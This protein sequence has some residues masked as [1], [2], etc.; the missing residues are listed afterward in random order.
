MLALVGSTYAQETTAPNDDEIFHLSPFSVNESAN[1][2]RYQAVEASSGSRIRMNLMD[3]TQSIS[4]LTNEFLR[5]IDTTQLLDA[6][7]Y[8]A[9]IGVSNS[10]NIMDIM[11]IRGFQDYGRSTV[12]GLTQAIYINQDPIIIERMEVVKGPNAIIAPQGLP[13]GVINNVTKKPLF[14]N[15]GSASYQVGRYDS[16][17]AEVDA[18]Y[19]VKD[20]KLA[21]R[22][23]GAVTDADRYLNDT[24]YQNITVMPMLTY[25]FS[26][27]AE[28]TAQVIA[29]N[30]NASDGQS[31]MSPY[32]AGRSNIRILDG[33]PRDFG[34]LGR[35]L[36]RH[37]S[38]QRVQLFFTGQITD[39]LST[40]VAA[41]WAERSARVSAMDLGKLY[42]ASGNEAPVV[43]LNPITG[44]WE[45][46]GTFND[47]PRYTLPGSVAWITSDFANL[48]NDFVF[49]H[50]AQGWK[51]QTVVGYAINYSSEHNR[52][53]DHT[54]SAL[55]DFKDPNYTPPLYTLKPDWSYNFSSV[56]RSQQVYL[57]QVFNLFDD[58]LVLSGSLSQNRYFSS[59]KENLGTSYTPEKAEVSLPS[60]GIVYKITPEVSLYY[61]YSEQEILGAANLVQL[62]PSHTSPTRQHEGGLRLKLFDGRLYTTL[63][64]FDILQDGVW[65][66]ST[67]NYVDPTAPKKPALRSTRTAKGFE[68]EFAWSPTKN[69]SVIGSYTDFKNR[70]QDNMVYG[71]VAE[72]MAGIW[73]TYAFSDT[74]PL[75]G[76]SVGLGANYVGERAGDTQGSY[77]TPPPGFPPVRV[78]PV[79]WYPSYTLVE[80]NVSYRFNKHWK[81]Q[82]N[83]KNLLDRDYIQGGFNHNV[84][85]S[86][87]INPKLT[88][89]YEF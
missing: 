21:L 65:S 37:E 52:G 2:G 69:I 73:G 11:N 46:N 53:K 35:N 7:K 32:A 3:S 83:I 74:G 44:E 34:M 81:A 70:D 43:E 59:N 40:R 80:A 39:K 4:V 84:V 61:G 55:L 51:S 10:S 16:N 19:V 48:Q 36:T 20:D 13:G 58:R 49:E 76:L 62:I 25:R 30:G 57:Y 6:V 9:G 18:N 5:D 26:Q 77:T 12:D 54:P 72:R 71:N 82:L 33:I 29:F 24:A 28:L 23:V 67:E 64:Y 27:A 17:R 14:T 50:N 15:K 56:N 85:V 89:R 66:E 78:Q 38:G 8:T 60:A 86:T 68:F 88:L 41:K 1:I 63:T 31:P 79:F 87:P 45:W 42:D 75:R 47:N 22:V